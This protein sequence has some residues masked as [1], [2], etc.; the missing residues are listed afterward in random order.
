MANCDD[1]TR[2]CLICLMCVEGVG[3]V[4]I[5]RLVQAAEELGRSL[6]HVIGLPAEELADGF[7]LDSAVAGAIAAIGAPVAMGKAALQ[8]LQSIGARPLFDGDPEYPHRLTQFLG[9]SAP[10][11]V[12]VRG[13]P[14][15]VQSRTVAVVGSRQPTNQARDAAA[16]F[17][18]AVARAHRTVVSGGAAGIDTV[19]HQAALRGGAT[20]VVPAIGVA[21][22]RWR[23]IETD[24]LREGHWCVIGQFRPDGPWCSRYALIRNHTIVALSDAVVACEPRDTGGTWRSSL[25]ALHLGKPLFLVSCADTG[26]KRRG[27]QKLARLGGQ[28]LDARNM[29]EP[30]A[31]DRLVGEYEPPA[32]PSQLPLFEP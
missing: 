30:E 20:A 31:F 17:A 25:A 24:R 10:P 23:G 8:R 14:G 32:P 29:P 1:E 5:R 28:V 16:S 12:F 2:L 22:F 6:R 26:A 9:L 7:G 27:L 11:V 3:A 15:I 4:S 21:R 13:E 18:S 19:A